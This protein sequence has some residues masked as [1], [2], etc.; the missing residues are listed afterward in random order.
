MIQFAATPRNRVDGARGA[1]ERE[2]ITGGQRFDA[3]PVGADDVDDLESLGEQIATLAAPIHAATHQLLVLIAE[4]DRRRGWELDG[5]RSCAHWLAFRTGMDLVTAREKVRVARALRELPR[6][7]EAMSRGELSFAKVRALTRAATA[8]NE[9]ELLAFAR[10]TTAA[11]LERTVRSMKLLSRKDEVERERERHR[12]RSFSVFP[13][14]T[15]MYEV[16]GRLD[17]EVGAVLMRAIEAAGDAL[18]RSAF[19]VGAVETEPQQRRADAL[20]LVAERA[21]AAGFGES[22]AGPAGHGQMAAERAI[23]GCRSEDGRVARAVARPSPLRS[24]Q[25]DFHHS[26]PPPGSL[27]EPEPRSTRRPGVSGAGA[28]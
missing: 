17:P 11:E 14:G 7:G 2:A 28:P 27:R 9:G 18:Y 20:G 12:W 25:G 1:I 24:E 3:D 5:H 21:L 26:A 22:T 10:D 6:T 13:D 16:R 8:K 15:G 19:E 23:P 4:F